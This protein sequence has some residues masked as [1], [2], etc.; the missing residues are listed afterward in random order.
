MGK[1]ILVKY[2]NKYLEGKKPSIQEIAAHFDVSHINPEPDYSL[3]TEYSITKR[4]F[5]SIHLRECD[6]IK[7]ANHRGVPKLWFSE[8]WANEFAKFIKSLTNGLIP[9]TI[10]EI[11]PPYKDYTGSIDVF[12]DRY[13]IFEE[14]ILKLFPAVCIVVE[15]RH[16][17]YYGPSQFLLSKVED[18]KFNRAIG[19]QENMFACSFRYTS[20][21]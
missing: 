2:R 8:K 14:E 7:T 1:F 4:D 20:T 9:P 6:E 15:N 10:I 3:H 11:H 16:K 5:R 13:K 12:L 17:S 19:K 21:F 18:L